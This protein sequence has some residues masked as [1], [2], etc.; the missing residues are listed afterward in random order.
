MEAVNNR[1]NKKEPTKNDRRSVISATLT[2][3]FYTRQM[4]T[5]LVQRT[6][7]KVLSFGTYS[8]I[9]S[10]KSACMD[11]F[12]STGKLYLVKVKTSFWRF[13]AGLENVPAMS[14]ITFPLGD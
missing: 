8:T 14:S 4:F 11:H 12:S 9:Q 1:A 13:L 3:S 7:K 6:L 5:L 2:I 10:F